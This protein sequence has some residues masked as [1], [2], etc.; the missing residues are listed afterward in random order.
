MT[1]TFALF[2]LLRSQ[3]VSL[4][5]S[6]YVPV[7]LAAAIVTVLELKFPH[8]S[9]W[10]PPVS[11]IKTDLV[12]MEKGAE[13]RVVPYGPSRAAAVISPVQGFAYGRL[14]APTSRNDHSGRTRAVNP[15]ELFVL[16]GH[17]SATAAYSPIA[18]SA[19]R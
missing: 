6:T 5:M 18:S 16:F 12:F 11:E 2:V 9:E 13:E 17:C 19:K 15:N 7:L 1:T 8:R 10:R 3:G 14:F 4:V